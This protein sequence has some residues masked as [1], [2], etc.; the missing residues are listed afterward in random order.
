MIKRRVRVCGPVLLFAAILVAAPVLEAADVRVNIN[1]GPPPII[2]VPP[3]EVV[4]VP[5]TQVYFVPEVDFDI[6]FYDGYWW[7]PRGERWYRARSY[8]GPW[9][10]VSRRIIPPPIHRVPRDYRRVYVQERRVPYG[11]WKRQWK[12]GDRGKREKGG[13]KGRGDR[14]GHGEQ[15]GR[16]K[17]GDRGNH[18]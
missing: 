18:R 16:D 2:V 15:R 17:H 3:R 14:G 5:G 1:L 12:E 10:V 8:D 9:R 4:L 7:S 11:Q 13:P 6:F